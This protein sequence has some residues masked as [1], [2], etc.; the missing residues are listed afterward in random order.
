M[1]M[2]SRFFVV[3]VLAFTAGCVDRTR[4]LVAAPWRQPPP[5]RPIGSKPRDVERYVTLYFRPDVAVAPVHVSDVST[6][7]G[8]SSVTCGGQLPEPVYFR[9][10]IARIEHG[11]PVRDDPDRGRTTLRFPRAGTFYLYCNERGE[12]TFA[13]RPP[14]H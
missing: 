9:P 1:P 11:C 13:P 8:G 3:V 12:L 2:L 5:F 10:G 4:H 7:E 14:T 6:D